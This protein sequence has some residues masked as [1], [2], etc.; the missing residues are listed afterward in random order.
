MAFWTLAR[1]IRQDNAVRNYMIISAYGFVLLF[2]SNQAIVL[3]TAPYP[4]FGLATISF[5]GLSSYLLMVGIYSSAISVSLDIGLRNAIRKSVTEQS[6]LLHSIGTAQMEKELQSRVLTISRKISD[7]IEEETGVESSMT[8]VE[9][10][11][12]LNDVLKE[13]KTNR[14]NPI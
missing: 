9:M 14:S 11:Q 13:I 3:V 10:K 6:N 2:A 1:S 4:P 5:V 8:E 12:Y 7:K